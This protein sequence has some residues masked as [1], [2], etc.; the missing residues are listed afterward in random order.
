MGANDKREV[1]NS[2]SGAK[3]T[4]F[5]RTGRLRWLGHVDRAEDASI[6]KCMLATRMKDARREER[7]RRRWFD[8]ES[9]SDNMRKL[10]VGN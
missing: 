5:M 10:R 2:C 1:M 9:V 6:I 3:V 4:S 7:P 8:S